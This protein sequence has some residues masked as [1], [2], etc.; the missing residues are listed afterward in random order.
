[1]HRDD[2]MKSDLLSET[3]LPTTGILILL[4]L[5][6]FLALALAPAKCSR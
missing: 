2:L 5:I 3:V 6:F 1:M 4:A